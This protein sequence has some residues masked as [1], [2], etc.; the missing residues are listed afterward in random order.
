MIRGAF[1][2]VGFS[3]I[4]G[5]QALLLLAMQ[6]AEGTG[7]HRCPDHDA[8]LGA[9]PAPVVSTHG[10]HH[11]G[12]DHQDHSTCH[13][14]GACCQASLVHAAPAV[15]GIVH[16]A[17]PAAPPQVAAGTV[18]RDTVRLLPFAIGPPLHT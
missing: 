17:E 7:L 13:C 4:A 16:Q 11:S 2:R 6:L 18:L 8:G 9:G 10:G 5:L 12:S 15:A 1:R 3:A 14:V